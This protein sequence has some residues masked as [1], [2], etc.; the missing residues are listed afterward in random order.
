MAT[1]KAPKQVRE[2]LRE[3]YRDEKIKTFFV[4]AGRTGGQI[5][6]SLGGKTAAKLMTKAERVAR[7]KKAAAASVK[8]RAAKAKRA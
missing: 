4:E 7:A 3:V 2:I 5:G 6:G 1:K 8:A